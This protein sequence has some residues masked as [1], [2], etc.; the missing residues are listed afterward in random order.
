LTLEDTKK[1]L[2][3]EEEAKTDARGM[4]KS[5]VLNAYRDRMITREECKSYLGEMG[6]SEEVSEFLLSF[7]DYQ[8]EYDI[9]QNKVRIIGEKYIRGVIS[10]T[11]CIAELGKLNLTGDEIANL[12]ETWDWERERGY[13]LPTLADLRKFYSEGKVT[14][15]EVMEVL[16][17]M[18]YKG[19]WLQLYFES[20]TGG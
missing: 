20:V 17:A 14:D 5:A 1:A 16:S 6:Y 11:D 3:E 4:S 13:R 19:K 15:E 8:R 12:M 2:Q 7:V 10:E 9:V 18:G